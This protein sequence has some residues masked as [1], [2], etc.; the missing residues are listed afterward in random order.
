MKQLFITAS[1][2]TALAVAAIMIFKTPNADNH[3]DRLGVSQTATDAEIKSAFRRQAVAL[4]PDKV[5]GGDGD[6]G[7]EEFHALVEARD[8]LLD[9]QRREEYDRQLFEAKRAREEQRYGRQQ[10]PTMAQQPRHQRWLQ[11]LMTRQC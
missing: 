2:A 4:H 7:N 8:V 10:N 6:A 9:P 11:V 3:Y 1:I 5:R